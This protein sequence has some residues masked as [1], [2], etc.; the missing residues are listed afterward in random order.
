MSMF[1]ID[2]LSVKFWEDAGDDLSALLDVLTARTLEVTAFGAAICFTGLDPF[3]TRQGL[4]Y[5]L[6]SWGHVA[7]MFF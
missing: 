6:R 7:A 1:L 5:L 4:I 2:Y 3:E